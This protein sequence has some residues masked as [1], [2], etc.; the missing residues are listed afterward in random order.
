MKK[1]D[2]GIDEHEHEH[3]HDH[4]DDDGTVTLVDA[5]GNEITFGILG[6]VEDEE[7]DM[8]YALLSPIEQ[9]EDE[10]DEDESP[11]DVFIF[12]Y[13]EFDDGESF[14][15]VEDPKEFERVSQLAS[16]MLADEQ[17]LATADEE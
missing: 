5:D 17:G 9:L 7:V 2:D 1:V 3:D 11:L 10:G 16:K 6:F 13:E 4:E 12:R 14:S 8:V 15:S